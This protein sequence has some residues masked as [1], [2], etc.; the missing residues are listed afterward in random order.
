MILLPDILPSPNRWN[1][2]LEQAKKAVSKKQQHTNALTNIMRRLIGWRQKCAA[3][4]PA[5]GCWKL[6]TALR[7]VVSHWLTSGFTSLAV[8]VVVANWCSFKG[9]M[10]AIEWG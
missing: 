4:Y 8:F 7:K 6:D 5:L 2:N 9:K 10:T 1:I 3:V